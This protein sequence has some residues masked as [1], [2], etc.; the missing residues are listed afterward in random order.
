MLS[1]RKKNLKVI[2]IGNSKSAYFHVINPTMKAQ[3]EVTIV[4]TSAVLTVVV[5]V[6]V[7]LYRAYK[8]KE[9]AEDESGDR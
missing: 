2:K 3:N 7:W 4:M 8:S 9:K 1:S 5:L 6:S